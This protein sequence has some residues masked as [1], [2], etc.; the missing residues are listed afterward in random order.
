MN[1]TET[2]F[3]R[4]TRS[5]IEGLKRQAKRLYIEWQLGINELDCGTSLSLYLTP[6]LAEVRDQFNAVMDKLREIDKDA[7]KTKL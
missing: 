7:P 1:M 2:K 3:D 6:S 4:I 5:R